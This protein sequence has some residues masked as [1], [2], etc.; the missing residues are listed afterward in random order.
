M[1]RFAVLVFFSSAGDP[2]AVIVLGLVVVV[3]VVVAVA[4]VVVVRSSC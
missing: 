3:V 1:Y 4:V 2:C